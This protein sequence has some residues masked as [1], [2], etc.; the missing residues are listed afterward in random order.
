MSGVSNRVIEKGGKI[1]NSGTTVVTKVTSQKKSNVVGM[2]DGKCGSC[3][4]EA[5]KDV[6]AVQCEIYDTWYHIN[7]ISMSVDT[8]NLRSQECIHWF[9]MNCKQ[10]SSKALEECSKDGR[11]AE[12]AG[13]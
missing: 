7:C 12:P 2:K 11:E 5:G 9:C 4:K 10:E 13:T 3:T 1:D 8:Y 6:D